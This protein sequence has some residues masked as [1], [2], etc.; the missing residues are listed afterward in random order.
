MGGMGVAWVPAS[1]FC[2]GWAS[3]SSDQMCL[4]AATSPKFRVRWCVAAGSSA[5]RCRGEKCLVQRLVGCER[6]RECEDG[7]PAYAQPYA[8]GAR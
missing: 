1:S 2:P 7:W 3:F 8:A 5:D 6:A 4:A